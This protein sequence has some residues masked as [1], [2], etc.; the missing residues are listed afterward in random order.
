MNARVVYLKDH[1]EILPTSKFVNKNIVN[2]YLFILPQSSKS[3]FI[4][5]EMCNYVLDLRG[6]L[7]TGCMNKKYR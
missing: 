4:Q 3:N 2:P 1:C 6:L 5:N 7:K